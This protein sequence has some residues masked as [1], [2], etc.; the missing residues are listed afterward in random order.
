VTSGGSFAALDAATGKI[1]WQ[2]ADP[3]QAA[4]MG[5]VSTANGVVYADSIAKTGNDMYALDAATG[6]IRWSFAGGGPVTGG[7]AIVG[8]TVYWGSGYNYSVLCGSTC[9]S[10]NKFYA[11]RLSHPGKPPTR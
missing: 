3:R 4:D 7:A 10:T 5:F 2:T 1:L 11:F 8:G 6:T 9:P